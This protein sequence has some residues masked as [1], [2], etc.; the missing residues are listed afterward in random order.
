M[1]L[2]AVLAFFL[3][4]FVVYAPAYRFLREVT[5]LEIMFGRHR[6]LL[7]FTIVILLTVL[8]STLILTRRLSP[9]SIR[10]ITLAV[11]CSTLLLLLIP[12]ITIISNQVKLA[13][14]VSPADVDLPPIEQSLV[15]ASQTQPDVYYIILDMLTSDNALA[16]LLDYDDPSFTVS[17][18]QMGFYV[19]KCSRSN[20][21]KTQLSITSSLNMDYIQSLSKSTDTS[22]LY[23]LMLNNRVRRSLEAAGYQTIAFETGYSYTELKDADQYL[24][25]I[26]SIWDWLLF[27][28]VTP[29]ESL[30][31]DISGGKILYE[32]KDSL[33]RQMQVMIDAS[34]L[35]YRQRIL[36]ELHSLA[37]LPSEPGPKFIFAHILAPHSPFVFDANGGFLFRRTPF[38]LNSDKEYDWNSFKLAY[39]N[40]LIYLR[41]VVL[42]LVQKI[43]AE[44][45]SPPVI[46]IQ[47]DHGIPWPAAEKA[48][49]DIFNA[50]Y[51]AGGSASGLYDEIS[52]VNSFRVVFND[53]FG[54]EYDL[55]SDQ[56]FLYDK[57]SG[58]MTL[59]TD[60]IPCP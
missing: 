13:R 6:Y 15:S 32:T 47:G 22:S 57:D 14:S 28:G 4:F 56:S 23:P 1:T 50:Y 9:G 54:T 25:T 34:Y 21:P 49:F 46:I 42:D 40:E 31:L 10:S 3:V 39:V 2:F 35:Q 8:F 19:P 58:S 53:L 59:F 48:Q 17:L 41:K 12:T 16:R 7:I 20:Y 55:L 27:P 30:I 38:S 5:I 11:N 37:D 45:E 52:P 24:Q 18:Q 36:F 51:L 29:F 60:S 26:S 43:I 44:S 33:S